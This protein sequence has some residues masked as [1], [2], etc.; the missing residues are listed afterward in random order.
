MTRDIDHGMFYIVGLVLA[1]AIG[2]V[3]GG[4]AGG[5]ISLGVFTLG[6]AAL[7]ALSASKRHKPTWPPF[8]HALPL[9]AMAVV[10]ALGLG[11]DQAYGPSSVLIGLA[12]GA[13][14]ALI[15][16]GLKRARIL[17]S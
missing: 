15:N 11:G 16:V 6:L 3:V 14:L 12:V 8:V 2:F 13:V 7:A 5:L 1:V 4:R 9:I 17:P 10:P